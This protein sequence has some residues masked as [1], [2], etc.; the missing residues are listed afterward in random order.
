MIND[1][2]GGFLT[3][4]IG[5]Y[6]V[7]NYGGVVDWSN[8]VGAGQSEAAYEM[9]LNGDGDKK[10]K[11]Y[12]HNVAYLW[13]ETMTDDDFRDALDQIKSFRR[14]MIQMQHCFS[15]GFAQ[16]LAKVRRVIMSSATANEPAWS[17]PDGTY[18]VFSYGFL[19]ALS[20]TQ[21]SGDSGSVNADA[22]NDG[23]VSMLEAFNYA[24]EKDDTNESPLYTDTNKTPSWGVMPNGIH[25]VI[26]AKAFL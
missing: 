8:T 18:S 13:G 5:T 22:N 15:G 1:H 24:S 26:G 7:G 16:R 17:R 21:L 2:G 11:V 23:Q 6:K 12:F 10:D 3:R 4:D 20:G 14:E 19:C 25:G 9:D